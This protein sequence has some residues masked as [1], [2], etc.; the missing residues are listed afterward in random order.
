MKNK[1]NL[2]RPTGRLKK[3]DEWFWIGEHA[4]K[5]IPVDEIIHSSMVTEQLMMFLDDDYES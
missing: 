5:W 3:E 4:A 1:F 2:N